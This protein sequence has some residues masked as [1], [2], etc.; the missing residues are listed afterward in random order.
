[1][2]SLK[3]ID[4]P[5]DFKGRIEKTL[6]VTTDSASSPQYKSKSCDPGS[7]WMAKVPRRSTS[8][9]FTQNCF[10]PR[11][12]DPLVHRAMQACDRNAEAKPVSAAWLSGAP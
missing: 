7:R 2:R 9:G 10:R 11:L 8:F 1:M 12:H 3:M 4:D 6:T 5:A